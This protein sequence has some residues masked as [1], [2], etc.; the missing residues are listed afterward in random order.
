MWDDEETKICSTKDCNLKQFLELNDVSCQ[1]F[2]KDLLRRI[3]FN[4][5]RECRTN[6]FA[7]QRGIQNLRRRSSS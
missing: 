7:L 2:S 6:S 1:D 5:T 3:H 4:A